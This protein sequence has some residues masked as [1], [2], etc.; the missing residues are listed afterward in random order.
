MA[1]ETDDSN[2][3]FSISEDTHRSL[4][5][6]TNSASTHEEQLSFLPKRPARAVNQ[7][8][9]QELKQQRNTFVGPRPEIQAR[10]PRSLAVS[11]RPPARATVLDPSVL[12]GKRSESPKPTHV[13]P[14]AE[15]NLD[16]HSTPRPT[17]NGRNRAPSLSN[18]NPTGDISCEIDKIMYDEIPSETHLSYQMEEGRQQ[19]QIDISHSDEIT[20]S[21]ICEGRGRA[22][23]E[24]VFGN[25]TF[26]KESTGESEEMMETSSDGEPTPTF[27]VSNVPTC[28]KVP[29]A[30]RR[31][32]TVFG[33]VSDIQLVGD[34]DA[35]YSDLIVV[36]KTRDASELAMQ[37][38]ELQIGSKS[39]SIKLA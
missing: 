39:F 24:M 18:G 29:M 3:L 11:K 13:S 31:L 5:S 14:R 16:L 25:S 17:P 34:L 38:G 12:F 19:R 10:M 9:I 35:R 33:P 26:E 2:Q 37:K 20:T 32:E 4:F 7:E 8:E 23:P 36:F 1:K 21:F 28:V 22:S 27:R 30:R 6:I 15:S